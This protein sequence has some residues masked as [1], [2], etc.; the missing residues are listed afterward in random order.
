MNKVFSQSKISQVLLKNRIIRSATHEGL[1]DKEGKPT[2]KLIKKY[3]ALAKGR[4]GAIITGYAGVMEN[5]KSDLYNMLMIN[6]D[7][8]IP[9]HEKLVKV[10]HKYDT[11]IFL[12]I[13]HCG[14]QTSSV[15]TGYKP[16]AP[17]AIRD[18]L[19]NKEI[20]HELKEKEIY[21]I[22]NEFVDAIVRAI[23]SGYDGVQ[24]HLAHGYL[25][26]SFL[27]PHMNTRRDKWGGNTVNRFR[28]IK[29]ILIKARER[30][31]N[32]PIL[33]K[34]NGHEKSKDGLKVQEAITIAKYL[35][36]FKCDAI[37]VSC[38]VGEEGFYSIRGD[39]PFSILMK[40]NEQINK[41]PKI[42]HPIMR[43]LLKY[44]MGSPKPVYLYNL[45]SAEQIKQNV[46]IPVIVVGGIR[47]LKDINNIIENNK[48]DYVSMSRPFIIESNLVTKFKEGKQIESK[49]I[50]CNYCV[51]GVQT[52]PLKCYY[53]KV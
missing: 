13:A 24:L 3:K 33:A 39:F 8:L 28:I 29:E 34:I 17:S 47:K 11:P 1:A 7:E 53:G 26:S 27:S 19:Y 2:E 52:G 42:V 51:I 41:I 20:P 38:G 22:I 32:Y 25:L 49:C 15:I 44:A 16:V 46:N 40:N 21:E 43:Y 23:K 4:V 6:K 14:R 12:Q 45:S 9:Y 30:V 36:E 50:D 35:E 48:C 5:G 10:V 37:E 31:G 18:K